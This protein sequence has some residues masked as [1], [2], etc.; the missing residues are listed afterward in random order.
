MLLDKVKKWSDRVQ[1][2]FLHKH[3]A[4]Y[5]LKVTV[6]KKI[7]HCL[8]A[9]N[10]SKVQCNKLMRLILQAALPKAGF[11]RHFPTEVIHGPNST[12][13][14]HPY[15]TQLIAHLDILLRHGAQDTI[16]GQ[17]L[18]GNLET[19]KLELGLPG[20]LFVQDFHIFGKLST[21]SWIKGVWEEFTNIGTDIRLGE[22][23]ASLTLQRQAD[24]FLIEAFA[25]TG[26]KNKALGTLSRCR[27]RLCA[28]TLVDITAIARNRR[29]LQPDAQCVATHVSE[30]RTTAT[31]CMA[32]MESGFEKKLSNRQPWPTGNSLGRLDI[33]G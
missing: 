1:T 11:N 23:T 8:P 26:Y 18:T 5:A 10:L 13:I 19:A 14:H 28:V 12:N 24:R 20:P 4:A 16:I 6:L 7:E 30:T 15:T 3:D 9:L 25:A 22:H 21:Q 2:S 33:P 31:T 27:L 29:W 17:L 32:P